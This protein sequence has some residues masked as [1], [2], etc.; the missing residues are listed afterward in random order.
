MGFIE[1]K[2]I[3]LPCIATKCDVAAATSIAITSTEN[4]I[5]STISRNKRN[6]CLNKNIVSRNKEYYKANME[7]Y[8][9]L[10]LYLWSGDVEDRSST[11]WHIP[12]SYLIYTIAIIQYVREHLL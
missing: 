3:N 10:K 11:N 9:N 5:I 12:K 4:R 1:I 2:N 7:R 6:I 8:P